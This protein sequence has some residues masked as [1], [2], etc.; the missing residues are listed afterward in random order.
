LADASA[1]PDDEDVPMARDIAHHRQATDE[2]RTFFE[3][4]VGLRAT[5]RH[6]GSA[7]AEGVMSV[8]HAIA[9]ANAALAETMTPRGLQM[10]FGAT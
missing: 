6:R 5:Y 10:G 2:E 9:T 3:T 1:P 4:L 7:D 8:H